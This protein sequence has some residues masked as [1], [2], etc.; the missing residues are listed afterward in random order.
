M[1]Y[2]WSIFT[3]WFIV[4]YRTPGHTLSLTG[5]LIPGLQCSCLSQVSALILEE[6]K[7]SMDSQP[8]ALAY[9]FID[10]YS[11]NLLRV[12]PS[13]LPFKI[14]ACHNSGILN[15]EYKT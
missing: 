7:I 15:S 12:T 14:N 9:Q 13:P 3:I 1:P 10:S 4:I 8:Q 2:T 6:F 11:V 5:P